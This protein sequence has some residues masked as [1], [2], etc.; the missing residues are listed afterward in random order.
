MTGVFGYTDP[1]PDAA[2]TQGKTPDL[3]K[4]VCK[5]IV[6]RQLPTMASGDRFDAL[7]RNRITSEKT[8]DQSYTLAPYGAQRA[9]AGAGF[10]GDPEIE[11]ILASFMRPPALGAA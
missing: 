2:N 9:G 8:R 11:S 7:N 6:M 5:L 4:H 1:D 10:T 3:I